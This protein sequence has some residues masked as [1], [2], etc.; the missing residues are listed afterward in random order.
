M[1]PADELAAAA[2]TLRTGRFTG[3]MTATPAVAAL[4][5]AREPIAALLGEHAS[6][7]SL[8]AQLW[9]ARCGGAPAESE[10]S[11]ETRKALAVA[12]AINEVQ[13]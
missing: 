3:A 7:A 1:S 8:F 5:R 13:R 4:L 10:Y 6:F 11:A 9:Q 12:R 2:E